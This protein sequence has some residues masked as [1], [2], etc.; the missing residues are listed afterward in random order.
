MELK[1]NKPTFSSPTVPLAS[2]ATL[3]K[4]PISATGLLTDENEGIKE[5]F[6]DIL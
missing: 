1:V 6:Y 5:T 3:G 4:P 2:S